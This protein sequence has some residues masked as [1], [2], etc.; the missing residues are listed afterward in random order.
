MEP[1]WLCPRLLWGMGGQVCIRE[2]SLTQLPHGSDRCSINAP[3][4]LRLPVRA[5]ETSLILSLLSP[6]LASA[7][8]GGDRNQ[9]RTGRSKQGRSM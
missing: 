1:G 8:Q 6:V 9:N 4:F 5:W 7:Y 3:S 2:T